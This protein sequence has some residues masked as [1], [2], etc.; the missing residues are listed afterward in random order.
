MGVTK[1][2]PA[3]V[4]Y[5]AGVIVKPSNPRVLPYTPRRMPMAFWL[6]SLWMALIAL[7]VGSSSFCGMDGW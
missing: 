4:Q 2:A 5:A 6:S 3:R 1:S 7:N